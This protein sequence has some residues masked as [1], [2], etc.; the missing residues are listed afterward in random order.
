MKATFSGAFGLFPCGLVAAL[1]LAGCEASSAPASWTMP[2]TT[3]PPP[4][5]GVAGGPAATS[6]A[7]PDGGAPVPGSGRTWGP[8]VEISNPAIRDLQS[9]PQVGLD[10]AGNA[11]AVWRELLADHTRNAVWASRYSSGAAWSPPITIDNAVG[12]A[13]DPH[14]AMTPSGTA[15]V[16]FGQSETNQGGAQLLVASRF[17]GTWGTPVTVS[18]ADHAPEQPFVAVGPDGA[19]AVVFS[20]SDGMFPRAW[21]ARASAAG[22]WD[23]PAVMES[24]V[25]PGWE[26]SV[27]VTTNGDAVTTWT[28]TVG[29][30]AETSVWARR[31]HGGVWDAP[32]L[33]TPDHGA[34]L[35][36]VIVSGDATG[37]VLAVW[38]QRL[39]GLLTL[40][41]ARM[42]A[43]TGTW[44]A[45]VTV[46][47]GA[48][49]VTAPH[50]S[51]DPKGDAVAVW[52]ETDR[53]VV[54]NRFTSST[55]TWGSPAL[56]QARSTGLVF[57]PVPRVGIDAEG[58]AVATWVQPVGSPPLPHLFAAHAA[59]TGGAWTA[60][61]DLL[62]DPSAVAYA[63]E[64]QLSANAKGEAIVV[65]SQYAGTPA[66]PGIWARVY[67]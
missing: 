13:S 46:N 6:T 50:V 30:V 35:G 49:E 60:P 62:A 4:A 10:D 57:F 7:A 39:A 65:W 3:A 56:L 54:A 12:N 2:V 31:N 41:S 59:A 11:V 63:T 18:T 55:S 37:S 52:F 24:A 22:A 43:G 33:L 17:T 61:I 58:N 29:G 15:L 26:P 38:S 36:S 66:A 5:P 42:N 51:V 1:A 32:V 23:V 48:R 16:A 19:A 40:R 34:V 45:P 25:V 14:L 27:T 67:R 44:S 8:A 9:S 20:A 53:G 21:A 64:M 47:D 28:E